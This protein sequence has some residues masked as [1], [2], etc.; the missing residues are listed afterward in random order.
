MD[1]ENPTS[2]DNQQETKPRLTPGWVVGFVD[3]EGCFSVSI[4]SNALARPTNGWHVQPTFQV[5]QHVDHVDVLNEL[6]AFFGCGSVRMKGKGSSVAVYVVHSTKLLV[7][8]VL[9]FFEQHQLQVKRGDF[10][11]FARIVRAV[12]SRQ[13]H[14]RDVFEES[15]ALPTV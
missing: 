14:R 6:R 13:H 11:A 2:A 15:C 9:P 3:G 10:E 8:H 12:R 7:S 4:H 1:S 5:S